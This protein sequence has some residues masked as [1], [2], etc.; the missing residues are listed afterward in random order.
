[1][2][3]REVRNFIQLFIDSELD[4]RTNLEV[5]EHLSI[6][7]DC[8][9]RFMQE[10]KIQNGLA[11]IFSKNS[12]YVKEKREIERIWEKA[13]SAINEQKERT[14]KIVL[15]RKYLIP[16]IPAFI[17]IVLL[18]IFS[19][20]NRNELIIAASECHSE[21]LENKISPTIETRK[22]EEVVKYFSKRFDFA[23]NFPHEDNGANKAK[24]VGA[25]L[26]YLK[27]VPVAYVMYNCDNFP[28]SLFFLNNESLINFP[29][30]KRLLIK[31]GIIEKKN[32]HDGSNLVAIRTKDKIV[33]AVSEM[34]L[35]SLRNFVNGYK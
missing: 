16:A 9:K 13:T 28:L 25:R 35:Q 11:S 12:N 32:V 19:F 10:Q 23:I 2:Q 20:N 15:R 24:L 3:C 14:F 33:C 8:N 31:Y 27:K 5:S 4:A 29:G 6:C 21:Y 7:E 34:D 30:A 18:L 26:C 22:N 17:A 1:M